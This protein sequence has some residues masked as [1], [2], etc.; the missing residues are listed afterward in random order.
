MKKNNDFDFIKNEFE[1][2]NITAPYTLNE[3]LVI[4]RIADVKQKK[5][6]FYQKKSFKA[7]VSAA[8]CIAVVVTALTAAKPYLVDDKAAIDVAPS[9]QEQLL[10]TFTSVED[11]KATVK[12]IEDNKADY[13][14]YFGINGGGYADIAESVFDA[15][16]KDM[17]VTSSTEG[18]RADSYAD[19]YR[20]VDAVDEGDIIKNDGEYIYYVSSNHNC[21][22]IY[23][24][25]S[26]EGKLVS[27]IDD[28]RIS[29]YGDNSEDEYIQDIYIYNDT[30]VVNTYKFEYSEDYSRAEELALVH[31]FDVSDVSEPKQINTLLQSGAYVSSRLIGNQLYFVSNDYIYSEECKSDDDYIP[32]ICN[33]K[34]AEKTVIPFQ[35]IAYGNNPDTASYLIVSAINIETGEC[36]TDTKA[37]FGAGSNMYCNEN[38]MY[39]TMGQWRWNR[40]I[41][42]LNA[43]QPIE[44]KTQIV[45]VNLSENGIQFTA[46]CEVAGDV[47]NQFSLDE[48]D[49]KLRVATTSYNE[50][51]ERTNNLFVLD[52]SLNKI[53]EITGFADNESI[54][55]VRFVGDTAYVITYEQVDPLFIIDLSDPASPQIKG[56]VEIT[57]FSSLLV[58]VDENTL[59]GIGYST[60]Q[61]EYGEATDGVKLALFD[62]S[63]HENPIV[64]DSFVLNDAF[65]EAQQN[66]HALVVNND[67]GYYAIPYEIFDQKTYES[68]NGA[69]TFEINAGKID[70]TNQF[71]IDG[72]ETAIRCTYA[73]D[74]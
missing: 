13:A 43:A 7:V 34:N 17:A 59:L 71:V 55:A 30:L 4:N 57:G 60:Y 39:I 18:G 26:G 38:N 47:N 20:Q 36:S 12:E 74:N 41:A 42:L 16:N 29:D 54:Q 45:K 56:E 51:D 63:D 70:V 49:G 73:D 21:I 46:T 64:L 68:T 40:D 50:N 14:E 22:K 8:A 58:P 31:L 3:N 35:D 53:G 72:E 1:K 66:H 48:K 23:E 69:L 67:K 9:V 65:S 28:F 61:G 10:N 5:I 25:A 24:T 6:R 15:L 27:Q 37:I 52:E 19:T 33:G 62:I 11:I 2:E 32:Y 44:S